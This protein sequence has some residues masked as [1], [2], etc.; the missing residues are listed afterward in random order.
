MV[1][2]LMLRAWSDSH[3]CT[4]DNHGGGKD[5]PHIDVSET[6]L[7]YLSHLWFT[8]PPCLREIVRAM[9]RKK[10]LIALLEP[11]MSVQHGGYPEA[12][13]REILISNE[14]AARL[15]KVMGSQV[16]EWATAWD[17][18]ELRLP[19]GQEIV[20]VL[21]DKQPA[22][23]W[24]RLGDFQD[25]S[26]RL[27]AERLVVQN[28]RSPMHLG[29]PRSGSSRPSLG[30]FGLRRSSSRGR[31]DSEDDLGHED[32]SS[33]LA[34][35]S[36]ASNGASG[37]H[38]RVPHLTSLRRSS[39]LSSLAEDPVRQGD[40]SSS[41]DRSSHAS[42]GASGFRARVIP[43]IKQLSTRNSKK[44]HFNEHSKEQS[45]EQTTYMEG[46]IIQRIKGG[47]T[48][49]KVRGDCSYHLYVSPKNSYEQAM[50]TV[51]QLSTFLP[52][53]LWTD[54]LAHLAECEHFLVLLTDATWTSE[55]FANEVRMA[56]REGVHRLLV[57]EVPGARLGDNELRGACAFDHIIGATPRDLYDAKLYNEIAQNVGGAEWREAGVAK[58]AQNLCQGSGTRSAWRVQVLMTDEVMRA[59]PESTVPQNDGGT[60][61]I[62]HDRTPKTQGQISVSARRT[63]K[64][65]PDNT[66][67]AAVTPS[68]PYCGPA[69][70]PSPETKTALDVPSAAPPPL[71][72]DEVMRASPESTVPQNDGGT[73]IITHDRTPKTQGQI[74]VSPRRTAK[75]APDN[76]TPAPVTPPVPVCGP[77]AEPSPETK[78]ALDVPSAAPP[79]LL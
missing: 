10:P 33:S 50:D 43:H 77:A 14:Y 59:S 45:Y 73:E 30:E 67:P 49:P 47:L 74:S 44:G 75:V 28:A 29:L 26:M 34:R 13:C 7:C 72:T 58:L 69:A 60:E 1:R 35:S 68:V 16:N 18:P 54:E 12:K 52:T 41:H 56:M 39:S 21:F 38:T 42:N 23:V 76:T 37:F 31:F 36:R 62:T 78:T 3:G 55:G 19:T 64:V 15:E 24:Y 25:V 5:F 66:S 8:N 79:P 6:V 48:M 51:R 32:S 53:L 20:E 11:D 61:I 70:E 9:V 57:H 65:A 40:P 2:P 46:E 22:V 71:M 17:M 63:A 4:V 27:I